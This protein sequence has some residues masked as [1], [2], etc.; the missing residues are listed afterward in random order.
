MAVSY[1]HL[2][3]Y[4]RQLLGVMF[5]SLIG[6]IGASVVNGLNTYLYKDYF[7]NI[8]IQAQTHSDRILP[9]LTSPIRSAMRE[10]ATSFLF[11]KRRLTFCPLSAFIRR[12]VYKRQPLLSIP[13]VREKKARRIFG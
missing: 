1:T 6:M 13:K 10:T 12:D 5:F 3:V 11:L 7:G 2:D 8:K 9:G 4:K